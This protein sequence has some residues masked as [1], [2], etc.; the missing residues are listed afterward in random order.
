MKGRRSTSSDGPRGLRSGRFSRKAGRAGALL[1]L[2]LLP[3]LDVPHPAGK[4]GEGGPGSPKDLV[5]GRAF[6]LLL[7]TERPS[8]H[9][10]LR[11]AVLDEYW[12]ES[13]EL[14]RARRCFGDPGDPGAWDLAVRTGG[15]LVPPR[16]SL[17]AE[18]HAP[19][20]SDTGEGGAS[21]PI[22]PTAEEAI[23]YPGTYRLRFSDAAAL[24]IRGT[25]SPAIR[26]GRP[27]PS[28]LSRL[29]N[30]ADEA[31]AVWAGEKT[32]LRLILAEEDAVRLYRSVPEGTGLVVRSAER[33]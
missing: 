2:L 9:L 31:G 27:E 25:P 3:L 5:E 8:L 16:P 22:P 33:R 29:G 28:W 13:V 23:P 10:M 20:P 18:F 21:L 1:V 32:R 14:G 15:R 24:V 11:G 7:D 26:N 6:Y 12:V 30:R 17:P 4:E 19:A